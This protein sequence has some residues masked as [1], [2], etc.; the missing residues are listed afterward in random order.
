M[1]LKRKIFANNE[2]IISL[3]EFRLLI[4]ITKRNVQNLLNNS[5]YRELSSNIVNNKL[6]K[7]SNKTWRYTSY[8]LRRNSEY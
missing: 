7:L 8:T 5:V 3:T 6:P 2:I 4:I 1:L